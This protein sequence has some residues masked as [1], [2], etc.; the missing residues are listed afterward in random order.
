VIPAG[1]VTEVNEVAAENNESPKLLTL[2]GILMLE[3]AEPSKAFPLI[4]SKRLPL[5]KV[6]VVIEVV[7][8]K[9]CSPIDKTVFG[10]FIEVI[11]LLSRK[12]SSA[13]E[14]TPLGIVTDPVQLVFPVTML[15]PTVNVPLVPQLMKSLLPNARIG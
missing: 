10:M 5:S 8:L 4:E 13:I 2:S 3:I 14:V 1:S 6:I 12:A 11:W 15:F 7:F 9:A